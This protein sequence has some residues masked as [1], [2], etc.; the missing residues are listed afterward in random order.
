MAPSTRSARRPARTGCQRPNS[1]RAGPSVGSV[2]GLSADRGRHL[3]AGGDGCAEPDP[4]RGVHGDDAAPEPG[5]ADAGYLLGALLTSITLGLLIISALEGSGAVATTKNTVS[6]AATIALGCIALVGALM[7]GADRRLGNRGDRAAREDKKGPPRWQRALGRGSA[8]VTFVVG[9]DAHAPGRLV[10]CR[11]EPD[12]RAK[13]F[14]ARDR[15]G[16]DRLQPDHAGKGADFGAE[17]AYVS[18]ASP[19][20]RDWGPLR[21]IPGA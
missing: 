10:S 16:R 19:N 3:G 21:G 9:R 17:V 8:R 6:P 11:A 15:P 18:T 5:A 12:R 7:I 2:V 4:R 20:S 14:D 1:L 13:L